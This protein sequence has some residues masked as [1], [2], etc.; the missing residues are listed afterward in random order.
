LQPARADALG[1]WRQR[2]NYILTKESTSIERRVGMSAFELLGPASWAAIGLAVLTILVPYVRHKSDLLTS[3][4]LFLLG[5]ISFVGLSGLEAYW[6]PELFRQRDYTSEDYRNYLWGL[7]TFFAALYLGYYWIK[8]PRRAAD[9]FPRKWPPISSAVLLVTLPLMMVLAVGSVYPPQIPIVHQLFVQVGNKAICFALVLAFVVWYRNKLNP[10]LLVLLAIVVVFGTIFAV[11]QG[12]GRRTLLN[13]VIAIPLCMYWLTL[14]YRSPWL[15][16]TLTS[17]L[18]AFTAVGVMGYSQIRHFDRRGERLERTFVNS[19][20][21]LQQLPDHLS[22]FRFEELMGQHAVQLSLATI[23]L[24]TNG[25]LEPDPFNSVVFV[26][27]NPIPRE[28]W[29][30]KPSPLGYTLPDAVGAHTQANWGPGIVGHGF[31]EGGLHMVALYSLLCGLVLRYFDELLTRQAGNPYLLA[32]FA[33]MASHIFGWTRGD[34]GTF[35]IQI[36]GSCILVLLLAWVGRA[37]FG[38]GLIYPRTGSAPAR[39]PQSMYAP[40]L[41]GARPTS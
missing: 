40:P 27:T 41:F 7:V 32:A 37:L 26:V 19:L 25:T 33:A 22:E 9:R 16:L 3:W 35:N 30:D 28:Y 8:L 13:V 17:I 38:T 31:H 29:P 34:I 18:V 20:Q 5:T 14:R 10:A 36:V 12:G 6:Q 11:M 2:V 21:A 24:Y 4:N 39:P 15:N 1:F 23:H